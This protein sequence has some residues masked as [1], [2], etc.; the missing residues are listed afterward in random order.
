MLAAFSGNGGHSFTWNPRVCI[1]I[2]AFPNDGAAVLAALERGLQVIEDNQ[3]P[4]FDIDRQYLAPDGLND[5]QFVT[6]AEGQSELVIGTVPTNAANNAFTKFSSAYRARFGQAP[7]AFTAHMFDAVLVAGLAITAA[8]VVDGA[9]VEDGAAIRDELFTVTNGGTVYDGSFFGA[10]AADLLT[11]G[12]IDY[13][14]PSGPLDFDDKGDVV[15][16]YALWRVLNNNGRAISAVD[17]LPAERF[18]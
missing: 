2:A 12:D 17:L 18:Q 14:G 10:M 15:G 16:D 13:V 7:E 11:G 1:A 3:G 4:T 9:N 5:P 8:G 6:L